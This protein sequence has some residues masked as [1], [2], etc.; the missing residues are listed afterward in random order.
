MF[1]DA[2]TST[3]SHSQT[4]ILLNGYSEFGQCVRYNFLSWETHTLYGE[5]MKLAIKNF[6]TS[7]DNF[8]EYISRFYLLSMN[9]LLAE[10]TQDPRLAAIATHLNE[11]KQRISSH[12]LPL[13]NDSSVTANEFYTRLCLGYRVNYYRMLKHQPRIAWTDA[14]WMDDLNQLTNDPTKRLESTRSIK[15]I[16]GAEAGPPGDRNVGAGHGRDE[17]LRPQQTRS[18]PYSK[19]YRERPNGKRTYTTK[20]GTDLFCYEC[21]GN[22]YKRHCPLLRRESAPKRRKRNRQSSNSKTQRRN[23]GYSMGNVYPQH[24]PLY[25]HHMQPVVYPQYVAPPS[26]YGQQQRAKPDTQTHAVQ[27]QKGGDGP[28]GRFYKWVG[29]ELVVRNKEKGAEICKHFETL[30]CYHMQSPQRCQ[31]LHMCRGCGSPRHPVR[32]CPAPNT[33]M[34]G[35]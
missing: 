2:E 24:P 16:H 30:R 33:K 23:N 8:K 15:D 32:N 4:D 35:T 14:Q 26:S 22:H 7:K 10:E 18:K 28:G 11:M 6:K 31:Y 5:T 1:D 12:F 20:D 9:M 21:E 17:R 19:Y 3:A 29:N 25:H 13:I 34:F 27:Q